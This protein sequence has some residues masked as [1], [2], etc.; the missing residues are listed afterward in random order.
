MFDRD[1]ANGCVGIFHDMD[2]DHGGTVTLSELRT[3]A[4]QLGLKMQVQKG[5]MHLASEEAKDIDFNHLS[6]PRKR[7]VEQMLGFPTESPMLER[8]RL[9]RNRV[10]EKV[11][12]LESI[13]KFS[14]KI[15]QAVQRCVLLASVG[16]ACTEKLSPGDEFYANL[17]IR[18]KDR[19]VLEWAMLTVEEKHRAYLMGFNEALWNGNDNEESGGSVYE[20]QT[21]LGIKPNSN[22][23]ST[24]EDCKAAHGGDGGWIEHIIAEHRNHGV[25]AEQRRTPDCSGKTACGTMPVVLTKYYQVPSPS[26]QDERLEMI[27]LI[28]GEDEVIQNPTSEE[29][30]SWV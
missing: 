1:S 28:V 7:D 8:M 2:A 15:E 21:K 18:I 23:Y 19:P 13:K 17:S 26:P 29:V 6:E 4:V 10:L 11:N 20:V 30:T 24:W 3:G 22:L 27:A 16:P 25:T 12:L 5:N 9:E 14:D